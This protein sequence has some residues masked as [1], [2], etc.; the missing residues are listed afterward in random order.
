MKFFGKL[1]LSNTLSLANFLDTLSCFHNGI[2]L[3]SL[4][5]IVT[6]IVIEMNLHICKLFTNSKYDCT[7]KEK[8]VRLNVL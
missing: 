3:L 5:Y 2:H 8:E 1:I 7:I 4:L 6:I